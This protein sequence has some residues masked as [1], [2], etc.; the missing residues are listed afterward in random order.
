M[1]GWVSASSRRVCHDGVQGGFCGNLPLLFRFGLGA[2][3]VE[4]LVA[5]VRPRCWGDASRR[6]VRNGRR[7]EYED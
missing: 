7:D 2:V 6:P 3:Q 4:R 1:A 5:L